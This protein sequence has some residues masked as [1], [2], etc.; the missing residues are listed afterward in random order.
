MI[1]MRMKMLFFDSPRLQRAMDAATRRARASGGLC[2]VRDGRLD[3]VLEQPLAAGLEVGQGLFG[4]LPGEPVRLRET[5]HDAKAWV[6]G[7]DGKPVAGVT[8]LPDGWY[9]LPL[10]DEE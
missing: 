10:D 3:D 9:V 8:D 4:R 2:P 6:M 1:Q 7:A 5:I